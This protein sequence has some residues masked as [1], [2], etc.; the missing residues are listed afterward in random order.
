MKEVKLN[1]PS[2]SNYTEVR[3]SLIARYE[4]AANKGKRH[5][6]PKKL[7]FH[8]SFCQGMENWGVFFHDK[9]DE[10]FSHVAISQL[11]P[12][13]GAKNCDS[14]QQRLVKKK[15]N[16][17]AIKIPVVSTHVDIDTGILSL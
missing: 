12:V 6:L 15:P 17:Q 4:S 11:I 8:F 2:V 1:W 13:I 5:Q 14:L 9:W 3:R 10:H 7:M 16:S